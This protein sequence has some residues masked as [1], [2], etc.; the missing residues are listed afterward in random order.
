MPL[1]PATTCELR[2]RAPF[3]FF[4][5]VTPAPEPR[6]VIGLCI[7]KKLFTVNVPGLSMTTWLEGQ[8]FNLAWIAAESSP[9]LG[10]RV[11][12]MAVRL[13]I[14]PLDIIPGFQGK[15]LSDGITC[16]CASAP[17]NKRQNAARNI[18]LI[19]VQLRQAGES[20]GADSW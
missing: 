8:V 13:G 9:P 20:S 12:Q 1:V 18:V 6:S 3:V 11:A 2:A 15:F 16:A 5:I 10:E 14:P 17:K 19:I 4:K 7:N